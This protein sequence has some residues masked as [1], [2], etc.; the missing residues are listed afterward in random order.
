MIYLQK[1][2][3]C[4]ELYTIITFTNIIIMTIMHDIYID[5]TRKKYLQAAKT[6][7]LTR[8]IN[9]RRSC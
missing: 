6:T 3:K 4:T 1:L 2:A 5:S 9:S 8:M 7:E